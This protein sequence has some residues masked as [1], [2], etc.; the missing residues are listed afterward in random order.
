MLRAGVMTSNVK[1][2][3]CRTF[4]A[5]PAYRKASTDDMVTRNPFIPITEGRLRHV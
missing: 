4:V 5:L 2:I 3:K 1:Q